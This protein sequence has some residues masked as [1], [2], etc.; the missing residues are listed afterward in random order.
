LV[1][2]LGVNLLLPHLPHDPYSHRLVPRQKVLLLVHP[3]TTTT[4]F[5]YTYTYT[6]KLLHSLHTSPR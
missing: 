1:P 5:T 6:Y 4:T 3:T 2:V